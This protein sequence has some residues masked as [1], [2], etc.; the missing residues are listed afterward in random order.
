MGYFLTCDDMHNFADQLVNKDVDPHEHMPISKH[1]MEGILNRHSHLVK[2][3]AAASLNPKRAQQATEETRDAMFVKLNSY[4]EMLH[5]MEK[6]SW[7]HYSDI[8]S[9]CIYNMDKLGNNMTKHRNKVIFKKMASE[10]TSKAWAFVQMAEGDGCMLWHITVCLTTCAD[11]MYFF[12]LIVD[13]AGW[14]DLACNLFV[15]DSA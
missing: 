3:V 14:W 1:I 4:I 6:I 15:V 11:G 10:D 8:P 2:I 5:A 12:S 13:V 7:K 9:D